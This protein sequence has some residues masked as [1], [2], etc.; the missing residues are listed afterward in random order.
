LQAVCC[1]DP[2][3]EGNK[4]TGGIVVETDE[5][6][7]ESLWELQYK[8]VLVGFECASVSDCSLE[9]VQHMKPQ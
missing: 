8:P 4:G 6:V 5:G 2:G 7:K 3:S 9:P 1:R